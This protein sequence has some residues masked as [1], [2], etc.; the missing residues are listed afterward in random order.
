MASCPPHERQLPSES[1]TIMGFS[2][3]GWEWDTGESAE[4]LRLLV[5][6]LA[7]EEAVVAPEEELDRLGPRREGVEGGADVPG[8]DGLQEVRVGAA[9]DLDERPGADTGHNLVP[10]LRGGPGHDPLAED[11]PHEVD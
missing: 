3:S 7:G 4:L 1:W 6:Q 8:R 9:V 11:L 2:F 5:R 10:R